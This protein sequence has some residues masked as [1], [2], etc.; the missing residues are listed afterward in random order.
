VST[1]K[2]ERNPIKI[3]VTFLSQEISSSWFCDKD[4]KLMHT[5]HV[6]AA[7]TADNITVRLEPSPQKFTKPHETGAS[8]LTCTHTHTTASFDA[9]VPFTV[10]Q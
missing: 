10:S 2:R 4:R 9:T 6:L 5:R 7:V 8:E 3:V 1:P